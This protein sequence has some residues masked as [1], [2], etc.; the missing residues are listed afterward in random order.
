[1]NVF[2]ALASRS[3]YGAPPPAAP[4]EPEGIRLIGVT[5]HFMRDQEVFGECEP[6]DHVYRVVRGAVRGFRVL[7]DGRRQICDFYLPGD[8]FGIERGAEHRIT[9]E[10][11]TDPG[12]QM[13]REVIRI[14]PRRIISWGLGPDGDQ[15]SKRDIDPPSAP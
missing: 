14:H 1:M 4:S 15:G 12:P 9:A 7:S 13:M 6:A 8:I 2:P 3:L 5:T 11:L 10:A